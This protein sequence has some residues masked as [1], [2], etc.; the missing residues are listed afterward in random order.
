M[1]DGV[2][3]AGLLRPDGGGGYYRIAGAQAAPLQENE[4]PEAQR[5]KNPAPAGG[6]R[7]NSLPPSKG[8]LITAQRPWGGNK[9]RAEGCAHLAAPS[10]C[11][12]GS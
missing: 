3:P 12:G 10:T 8:E 4:S 1:R 7:R 9:S 11:G 2:H 5:G 6:A